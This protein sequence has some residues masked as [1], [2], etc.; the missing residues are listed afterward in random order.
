[1]AEAK[2]TDALKKIFAVGVSGAVLSEELIKNYL[3][4]LKLPKEI[5]Q[6][7]LQN[8]QKSKEEITAKVSNEAIKMLTKVDWAKVASKFLEDH[9]VSINMELNFQRKSAKTDN[10]SSSIEAEKNKI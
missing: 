9:K 2:L 3:A 5:L 6:S 4:E 10:S 7:L 1:M 8:A